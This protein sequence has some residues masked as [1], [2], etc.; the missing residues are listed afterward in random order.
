M[1]H[2]R[3]I[4]AALF[5]EIEYD[6]LIS[7]CYCRAIVKHER[8]NNGRHPFLC[9]RCNEKFRSK[10]MISYHRMFSQ[11]KVYGPNPLKMYPTWDKSDHGELM[12]VSKK[13]KLDFHGSMLSKGRELAKRK[14]EEACFQT[15][16]AKHIK[17]SA[18]ATPESPDDPFSLTTPSEFKMES[19]MPWHVK[20]NAA[21]EN[22]ETSS[23]A[24]CESGDT[25]STSQD[26]DADGSQDGSAHTDD[27][28]STSGALRVV[29][30]CY[31]DAI[32]TRA[33]IIT[34]SW[35][36][37]R[38]KFPDSTH[39]CTLKPPTPVDVSG[40]YILLTEVDINWMPKELLDDPDGCIQFLHKMVEDRT[41]EIKLSSAFGHWYLYG[42]LV[43][44][45]HCR[46]LSFNC[47]SPN[48]AFIVFVVVCI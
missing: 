23:Y 1:T 9:L 32:Q 4:C 13:L 38:L 41:L 27:V 33:A 14:A 43:R 48:S 3:K 30:H 12:R 28:P 44:V 45:I 24:H 40:L 5:S 46:S 10:N 16:P 37:A 26:N 2:N 15:P 22:R 18:L 19:N 31:S 11:C 25:P 36:E 47:V 8:M 6:N 34:R 20:R 29:P 17:L 39:V 7:E 35:E 21:S 42:T